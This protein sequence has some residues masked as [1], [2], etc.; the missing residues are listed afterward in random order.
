VLPPF[1]LA[2]AC[3]GGNCLNNL[4]IASFI[5]LSFFSGLS[6]GKARTERWLIPLS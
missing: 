3:P 1:Y 6:H 4:A 2:A 5:F